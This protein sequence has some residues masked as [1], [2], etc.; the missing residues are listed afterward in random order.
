L[1]PFQDGN[2]RRYA[3]LSYFRFA[4]FAACLPK[5]VRVFL[6]RCAI[7]R[8]RLATADAFLMFLRAEVF[9][10]VDAISM[11]LEELHS[12]LVLLGSTAGFERTEIAPPPA[13]G[14]LFA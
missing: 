4:T 3:G 11:S 13:L 10:F 2:G 14:V 7:V 9:C 1:N 12:V 8:L 5:A 6:G